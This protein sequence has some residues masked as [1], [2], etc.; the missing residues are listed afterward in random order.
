MVFERRSVLRPL[1]SVALTVVAGC[2]S[3]GRKHTNPTTTGALPTTTVSNLHEVA[4]LAPCSSDYPGLAF[5][6]LNRGVSDLDKN[7]VPFDAVNVLV[8]R[9][10]LGGLAASR[11]LLS[12]T[13]T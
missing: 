12:V 4:G 5:D 8:C 3:G 9:Y 7:L 1:A 2:S 6:T 11:L 13:A 10:P